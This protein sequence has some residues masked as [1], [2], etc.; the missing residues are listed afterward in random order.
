MT[1]SRAQGEN[2]DTEG[3]YS[4]SVGCHAVRCALN[5]WC[6]VL[7][8]LHFSVCL[9]KIGIWSYDIWRVPRTGEF[10]SFGHEVLLESPVFTVLCLCGLLASCLNA[11]LFEVQ[12]P[13]MTVASYHQE[14]I[15]KRVSDSSVTR[16]LKSKW[17]RLVVPGRDDRCMKYFGRKPEGKRPL[18]IPSHRWEGNITMDRESVD[19]MCV[20][21]DRD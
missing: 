16:A 19:W 15:S 13:R 17:V 9:P 18:G 5:A 2:H 12:V 20:A 8:S 11:L 6:F 7:R 4:H 1:H 10:S 14:N 3:T 21:L